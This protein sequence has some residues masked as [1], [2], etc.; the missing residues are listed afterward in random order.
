MLTVAFI[1]QG[2]SYT[3]LHSYYVLSASTLRANNI[4]SMMR[5]GLRASMRIFNF[6]LLSE[7]IELIKGLDNFS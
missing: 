1:S 6:D 4:M 7:E 3:H 5:Q 2:K